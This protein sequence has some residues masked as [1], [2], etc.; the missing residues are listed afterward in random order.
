MTESLQR[1]VNLVEQLPPEEQD[2]IAEMIERELADRKWDELFA[3]E[4]S[5]RF[6][7][8]LS[9]KALREDDS[10]LTRESTDRW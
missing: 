7:A 2:A 6:L 1:I 9:S 3:T 10:G 4:A 5:D 8:R